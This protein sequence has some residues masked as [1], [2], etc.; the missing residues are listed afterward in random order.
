MPFDNYKLEVQKLRIVPVKFTCRVS[1]FLYTMR[2]YGFSE[3][4]PGLKVFALELE[5]TFIC[6]DLNTCKL[7]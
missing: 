7:E 2:F 3:I 6:H 4:K 5:K 1:E